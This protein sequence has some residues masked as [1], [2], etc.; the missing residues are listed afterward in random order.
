MGYDL[1]RCSTTKLQS[2]EENSMSALRRNR[3]GYGSAVALSAIGVAAAAALAEL[4][5][6]SH[7]ASFVSDTTSAKRIAPAP[8]PAVAK[9]EDLSDAFATVAARV[10]PSVVYIIATQNAEAVARHGNGQRPQQ[11]PGLEQIPPE[12]RRFFEMPGGG[13]QQ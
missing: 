1:R 2:L 5:R 4:P 11:G 8:T 7:G 10:K 12:F 6:A 9:L 3:W 13:E